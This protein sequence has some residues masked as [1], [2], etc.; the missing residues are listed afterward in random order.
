MVFFKIF[1]LTY[2][3]VI[4]FYTIQIIFIILFSCSD[5]IENKNTIDYGIVIN[6]INYNSSNDFDS[7][8][9]VEIY[10]NTNDT[11]S[12]GSWLLK[13]DNDE[14]VFIL[15][16]NTMI[17]PQQYTVLC[18]DTSR[19]LEL[20]PEIESVHGDLGFGLSGNSDHV[21]LYDANEVLVDIVEYDDEPP[22]PVMADGEGSTLELIHPDMDNANWNSW[23][24]SIGFGT[25][26]VVNSVFGSGI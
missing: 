5:K 14:H 19:F 10:N 25:P 1:Q 3:K 24:P 20:F 9:W 17:L 7:D 2:L 6:E 26:G 18:K 12:I 13:D 23:S 16:A 11:I 15:P 8:D 21:R 22:W 4:R